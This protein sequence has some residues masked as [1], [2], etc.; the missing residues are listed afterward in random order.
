[1]ESEK[2]RQFRRFL[3]FSLSRSHSLTRPRNA[4]YM[5]CDKKKIHIDHN[6]LCALDL[7]LGLI[8][9]K[10]AEKNNIQVYPLV[11]GFLLLAIR[12]RFD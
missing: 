2:L 9:K 4:N 7:Y 10:N 3:S 6:Q 11:F 5:F 8:Q 1:M 12:E